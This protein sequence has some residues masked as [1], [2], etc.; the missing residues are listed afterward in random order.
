[1]PQEMN[2]CDLCICIYKDGITKS[3]SITYESISFHSAVFLPGAPLILLAA[4]S[5]TD[6]YSCNLGSNLV[7]HSHYIHLFLPLGHQSGQLLNVK[8]HTAISAQLRCLEFLT[9]TSF[10][11]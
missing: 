1:M 10:Y 2:H 4:D 6:Y 9:L 5:G 3:K 11:R 7:V 8:A